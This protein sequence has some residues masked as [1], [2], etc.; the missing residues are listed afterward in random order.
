VRPVELPGRGARLGERLHTNMT[1]LVRELSGTVMQNMREPFAFFGHSLGALVAFEVA[2]AVRAAS[3]VEP[4][5]L[6]ASGANAPSRRNDARFLEPLSDSDLIGEM[7]RLNGT[8]AAVFEN[9]ELLD[10]ALPIVRAD[11]QLCGSFNYRRRPRLRAAIHV[12]GGADDASSTQLVAWGEE[13]S[14]VHTCHTLPG[15][16]FFIHSREQQVLELLTIR[17]REV[18]TVEGS[19]EAAYE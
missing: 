11:F 13:T 1:E 7:R 6:F 12:F 19:L 2:H 3:G 10:M 14:G 16:H 18:C 15:D 17:A 5:I 4:A 9:R 8:T